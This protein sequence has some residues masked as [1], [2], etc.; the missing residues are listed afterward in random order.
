[1]HY[2]ASGSEDKTA[3]VY[4]LRQATVLHRLRGMHGDA[5][6][7][8]CYSPLHP[9][10]ATACLDGKTHFFSADGEAM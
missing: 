2:L 4:D 10:L 5:V 1:M 9:Q 7:D 6:M 3:Y 8:V